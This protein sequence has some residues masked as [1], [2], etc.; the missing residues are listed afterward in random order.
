MATAPAISVKRLVQSCPVRVENLLPA[1]VEMDLGA[2][3][4]ELDFVKPLLALRSFGLQ[5][6]KLGL[7]EAR[8]GNTLRHNAKLI[9]EN[10]RRAWRATASILADFAANSNNL[11]DVIPSVTTN[12][13]WRWLAA[14]RGAPLQA[15]A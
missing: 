6:C 7:N 4:V 13:V 1:P 12:A 10:A 8:H 2:V 15:P 14:N 5:C 11:G 3:A 9:K